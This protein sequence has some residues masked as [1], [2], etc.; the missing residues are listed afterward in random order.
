MFSKVKCPKCGAK[1]SKER[2]TCAECGASIYL[3]QDEGQLTEVPLEVMEDIDELGQIE[4]Q[5]TEEPLEAI[6]DIESTTLCGTCQKELNCFQKGIF[7]RKICVQYEPLPTVELLECDSFVGLAMVKACPEC[8]SENYHDC[9]NSPLLEDYTIGHCLDCG[10]Y[11][12]LECGY[13]FESVEEGMECPHW[14]ICA[15]CSDEHGYLD[16]LEFTETI[17][18]TCEHYDNGCQLE[19]TLQCDERSQLLCSYESTVSICPKIEKMLRTVVKEKTS[20]A[21][22]KKM[23]G[24]YVKYIPGKCAHCGSSNVSETL[25]K[26]IKG[27]VVNGYLW[28]IRCADCG[29]KWVA[30]EKPDFQ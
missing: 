29:S 9:E 2:M 10:I 11:W 18:S 20:I 8:G 7:G 26:T 16:Q 15:D 21:D 5:V 3:G 14:E 28:D 24:V 4:S 13:V 22:S 19:D 27:T 23:E 30:L 1:N 12:C 25:K 17:C 6:E